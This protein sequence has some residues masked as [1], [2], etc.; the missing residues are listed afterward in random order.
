[1][2]KKSLPVRDEKGR[3]VW[4]LR[5][6][7][8]QACGRTAGAWGRE[9]GG[10]STHHIVKFRRSDEPCNFLRLCGRCHDLAEGRQVPMAGGGYWSAL[11]VGVCLTLKRV[12][13]A[14]EWDQDRLTTLFGRTLPEAA[15]L[16]SLIEKEYQRNR[17]WDRA[18]FTDPCP[19]T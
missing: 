6:G 4:A 8:C 5:H 7:Y 2:R 14:E 18:R 15:P 3:R 9:W 12:R 10:L 16:P 19:P 13:E 17:P 1:V 11:T